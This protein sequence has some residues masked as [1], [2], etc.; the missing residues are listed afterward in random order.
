MVTVKQ[1]GSIS[2]RSVIGWWTQLY[3]YKPWSMKSVCVWQR[4]LVGICTDG[5][6]SHCVRVWVHTHR[7]Y[8]VWGLKPIQ[9][10]S[11][12]WIIDHLLCGGES[13]WTAVSYVNGP[14]VQCSNE[15]NTFMRSIIQ[16]LAGATVHKGLLYICKQLGHWNVPFFPH[17]HLIPANKKSHY[18][19]AYSA[20]NRLQI[21]QTQ[22][23]QQRCRARQL[24]G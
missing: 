9:R 19:A 14:F 2:Q 10:I 11:Q 17:Y 18:Q 12:C 16:V 4:V 7:L 23:K 21:R 24:T 5:C 1:L 8:S 15:T 3:T 22:G 20:E 13:C 6:L